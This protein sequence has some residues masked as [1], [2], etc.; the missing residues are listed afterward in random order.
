MK[1]LILL[2]NSLFDDGSFECYNFWLA[3]EDGTVQVDA[4]LIKT[5]DFLDQI[6]DAMAK[7]KSHL[8]TTDLVYGGE[9]ILEIQWG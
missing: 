9:Q 1:Q 6:L 8:V 5:F 7:G 2:D 3:T 4:S